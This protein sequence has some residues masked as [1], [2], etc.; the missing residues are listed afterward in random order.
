MSFLTF[1][2]YYKFQDLWNIFELCVIVLHVKA[3]TKIE[4]ICIVDECLYT[5]PS[6]SIGPG[7]EPEGGYPVI[8]IFLAFPL[9]KFQSKNP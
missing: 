4:L 7:F 3:Y 6:N 9:E 2:L 8:S 5:P 1:E